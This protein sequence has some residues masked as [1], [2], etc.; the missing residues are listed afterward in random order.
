M[1][2]IQKLKEYIKQHKD[3]P[4]LSKMKKAELLTLAKKYG[5]TEEPSAP[6]KTRKASKV[7]LIDDDVSPV[8]QKKESRKSSKV[9]L[10]ADVS[11][12]LQRKESSM[13]MSNE[14]MKKPSKGMG[15][16][17]KKQSGVL[18]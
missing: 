16:K 13:P 18:L 5:Y 3:C 17:Y 15:M 11:P 7:P 2:T 14:E 6:R 1:L 12:V 10:I 8:L 4:P 9:P